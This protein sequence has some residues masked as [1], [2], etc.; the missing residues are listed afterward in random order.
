VAVLVTPRLRGLPIAEKDFDDLHA[1]H[2]DL[3]VIGA[4]GGTE[5]STPEETREFL[6]RK[7]MHW[8]KHG[9]GLLDAPAAGARRLHAH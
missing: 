5:P 6:D 2:C 7:L 4:F 8:R 9:L 1:L 3:R